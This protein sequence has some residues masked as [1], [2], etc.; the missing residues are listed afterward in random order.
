MQVTGSEDDVI[1]QPA[2]LGDFSLKTGLIQ[3]Q[4]ASPNNSLLVIFYAT[5]N[6]TAISFPAWNGISLILERI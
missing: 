4:S 1:E 2:T 3:V 6:N 5:E